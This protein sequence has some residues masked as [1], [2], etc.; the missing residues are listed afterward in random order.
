LG[1]NE[2]TVFFILANRFNRFNQKK[3]VSEKTE[4]TDRGSI[5]LKAQSNFYGGR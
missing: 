2:K 3:L 5:K 4:K 1:Q